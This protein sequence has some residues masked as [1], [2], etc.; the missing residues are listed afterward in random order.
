MKHTHEIPELISVKPLE[1]Y[2]LKLNYHNGFA[3]I[4][5]VNPLL[6]YEVFAP[7]RDKDLFDRVEKEFNA[8]VWNRDLEWSA[9]IDLCAEVIYQ[10]LRGER[11]TD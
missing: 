2:R 4:Y 9:H 11:I 1:G 8:V 5:D 6:Q 10:Q 7:L 3:G